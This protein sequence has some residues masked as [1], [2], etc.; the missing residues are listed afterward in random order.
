[1]LEAK[2]ASPQATFG[3]FRTQVIDQAAE[4]PDTVFAAPPGYLPTDCLADSLAER[5]YKAMWLRLDRGDR[6]PANFLLSMIQSIQSTHA[7]NG[8]E[9]FQRMRQRPGV[10]TGWQSLF[11]HLAEEISQGLTS[12]DALI[13][14]NIHRL[15]NRQPILGLF[16]SFMLGKLP[17][18]IPR[19][20]VSNE[21]LPSQLTLADRAILIE[22]QDLKVELAAA[23]QIAAQLGVHFTTEGIRKAVHLAQGRAEALAGIFQACDALGSDFV[24][25]ALKRS[26]DFT[27]FGIRIARAILSLGEPEVLPALALTLRLGYCRA[28][29]IEAALTKKVTLTG[30]WIQHLSGG[31]IRI[32]QIWMPAL[33]ATIRYSS[34]NINQATSRAAEFLAAQGAAGKATE[35][36]LD[37]G[38]YGKAARSL[39]NVVNEMMTCGQWSTL[40]GW[41]DRIPEQMLREWPW[42]V[43]ARGEIS[44]ARGHLDH[45]QRLFASSVQLFEKRQALKGVCHSLLAESLLAAWRGDYPSAEQLALAANAKARA[46]GLTR[47][48]G[49]TS[50][51]LGVLAIGANQPQ[52]ALVYF[53][54]SLAAIQEPGFADMIRHARS[55]A[56]RQADIQRQLER[57][58]QAYH[59]LEQEER[60]VLKLLDQVLGGSGKEISNL[61]DRYGWLNIPMIV[62]PM[63]GLLDPLLLGV[64]ETGGKVE[65]GLPLVK[66]IL[67]RVLSVIGLSRLF[68]RQVNRETSIE[69]P[70]PLPGPRI[71][72]HV[73]R[74]PGLSQ[75]RHAEKR[76]LGR[77]NLDRS[78]NQALD[79]PEGYK[80]TWVERP[81]ISEGRA[82]HKITVNLLGDF[83]LAIDDRPVSSWSS[84]RATAVLK[85]LLSHH[86]REAN[87]DKLMV[88][89]WPD[90][91]ADSARNNLNVAVHNARKAL[92][93]VTDAPIL[94]YD[95]G[96]YKLN[97]DVHIWIDVE[98]F[99]QHLTAGK[100][101]EEVSKF[102]GAAKEYEL[103][104]NLYQGDFLE[105]DPYEEWVMPTRERLRRDYIDMLDRLSL[106][107]FSR[108]QYNA[109]ISLSQ[110]IL[111]RDNCR[112]QAYRLLM[113][114][115]CRLGQHNQALREYQKCILALRN[116]LD[117]DPTLA[118]QE[119]AEKIRRR[120]CP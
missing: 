93:E 113:R 117:V 55:L 49:W 2:W 68:E 60:E 105:D 103:A 24:E 16:N 52:R 116:E 81:S 61:L 23:A 94:L 114:C 45:A 11:S 40:S 29:L 32:R 1:M 86:G 106:I 90:L 77:M 7:P 87:R 96:S 28:D 27:K 42:L 34:I 91:D 25:D 98:A 80:L 20:V 119:L 43:Y 104:A 44:T 51:H 21:S 38:E 76:E 57:H 3:E 17:E 30:P 39:S 72:L 5:S 47:F 66:R 115:L 84:L 14:E 102:D 59:S 46:A 74:G 92:Q 22:T 37:S 79:Q 88:S 83:Y 100:A 112:E 31:W 120:E 89:F 50:W 63:K 48:E 108:G 41:L 107:Y 99:N 19:I 62:K 75:G 15:G 56:S 78:Q 65:T 36:Y 85:Y 54:K 64:E 71:Q 97:P 35:L 70:S 8:R 118:T 111:E 53:E 58:Q 4:A 18:H 69:T 109:C 13:F 10:I 110:V 26:R 9:T 95:S 33:Q 12:S 82:E 73:P 101:L 6:D 67:N